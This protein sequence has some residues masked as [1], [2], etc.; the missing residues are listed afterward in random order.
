[1]YIGLCA[2]YPL[3]FSGFNETCTSFLKDFR[4][5]FSYQ[6]LRNSDQLGAEFFHVDGQTDRRT[7]GQTDGRKDGRKDGRT[8][9]QID[10]RRDM[11]K[12]IV[13]FGNFVYA[14]K[15]EIKLKKVVL[16]KSY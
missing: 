3:F 12:Q 11:M 13:I 4:K 14:P 2:Q 10:R 9:R 8:D 15:T 1:M 5:I 7:D 16:V 6:S